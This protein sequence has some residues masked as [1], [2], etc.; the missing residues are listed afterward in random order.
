MTVGQVGNLCGVLGTVGFAV[1][2]IKALRIVYALRRYDT[3]FANVSAPGGSS[4]TTIDFRA[5]VELQRKYLYRKRD[6]WN[7]FDSICLILGLV[8]T[9]LS[10]LLPLIDSFVSARP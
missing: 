5:F 8:L 6:A 2:A 1:P 7:T 4:P 9:A 10:Y 3:E